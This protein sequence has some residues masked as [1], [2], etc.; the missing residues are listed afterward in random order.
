MAERLQEIYK[1][2]KKFDKRYGKFSFT[3]NL[4][5]TSAL[6]HE[7]KRILQFIVEQGL[8]IGKYYNN[9]ISHLLCFAENNFGR[10]IIEEKFNVFEPG[11][12]LLAELARKDQEPI[13]LAD[14]LYQMTKTKKLEKKDKVEIKRLNSRRSN[15][16]IWISNG[17]RNM[18]LVEGHLNQPPVSDKE[19]VDEGV[20]NSLEKM[21]DLISSLVTRSPAL[22]MVILMLPSI[23]SIRHSRLERA[24]G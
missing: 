7:T 1:H 13:L 2:L 14:L 18:K 3:K 16:E 8:L 24:S 11:N 9:P 6:E 20:L 15:R 5:T 10:Q 21:M 12:P 17:R 4:S 22:Y 23:L 19:F